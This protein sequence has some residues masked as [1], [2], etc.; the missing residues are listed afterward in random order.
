MRPSGA[1]A[2]V[3]PSGWQVICPAP[4]VDHDEVVKSAEQAGGSPGGGAALG[5]GDQVVHVADG[6]W[7]VAAGKLTV[8]VPLDDGFAQVRRGRCGCCGRG[9]G[10]GCGVLKAGASSGAAQVGGEPAGPGQKVDAPAQG[11]CPA[12]VAG[13]PRGHGCPGRSG[14][15]G[16]AGRR[17]VAAAGA[18]AWVGPSGRASGWSSRS[19][20]ARAVGG[21]GRVAVRGRGGPAGPLARGPAGRPPGPGPGR[22]GWRAGSRPVSWSRIAQSICPDTIGV[23]TASQVA[24]SA[25]APD[26]TPTRDRRRRRRG[27][28]SSRA[29]AGAVG[30]GGQRSSP[31]RRQA[32]QGGQ[33]D[34]DLNLGR[35]GVPPGSML[36]RDQPLARLLQ[37]VVPPLRRGA[38]IFRAARCASAS[39]IT[40]RLAAHSGVRSARSRPAPPIVVASHTAR[41]ANPPHRH[42]GRSGIVRSSPGP[43]ALQVMQVRAARRGREQDPIRVGPQVFGEPFGPVAELPRPRRRDLPGR[44]RGRDHRVRGQPPRPPEGAARRPRGDLRE[45]PQPRL[46][47]VLPI[48][49]VPALA[50]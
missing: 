25:A 5:P 48:G 2:V 50:R 13:W 27:P 29:A 23:S 20:A 49:L 15:A 35:L 3:V 24:A 6:R 21:C 14:S 32:A 43:A 41:S 26:R 19:A 12:A 4:A 37:R 8:P 34:V 30:S 7:L 38:G 36:R 44:Q 18:V 47:P 10:A 39:R 28:G 16:T 22:G 11:G 45:R 1:V 31:G 33:V 46:R 42:R 17:S 40:A 9:P